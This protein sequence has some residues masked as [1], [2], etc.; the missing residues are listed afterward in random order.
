MKPHVRI[1]RP[2]ILSLS[3]CLG[4]GIG[5]A[6]RTAVGLEITGTFID[7]FEGYAPATNP[8]D[9]FDTGPDNS[10]TKVG[11][12]FVTFE[13]G[14]ERF[15]GTD[16]R[17]RNIHSH[18]I[19]P[20][21]D[22]LENYRLSGR[23][24]ISDDG[25]IGVT[26]LSQYPD[27]DQYYRLRRFAGTDFHLSPHGTSISGGDTQ[28]GVT[29]TADTW[30]RFL[31]EVDAIGDRTEIRAKVW[32]DGEPEPTAWQIDAYDDSPARLV[33]GRFGLWS[34]ARGSKYFDDIAVELLY[35][36]L[37]IGALPWSRKPGF[38]PPVN[39][40]APG[41]SSAGTS[42]R[43]TYR[44]PLIDDDS[45]I[46]DYE[47]PCSALPCIDVVPNSGG[48]VSTTRQGEP[49]L[50]VDP[51]PSGDFP[52]WESSRTPSLNSSEWTLFVDVEILGDGEPGAGLIAKRRDTSGRY[53]SL[54]R[55]GAG[56]DVVFAWNDAVA[57]R[58]LSFAGG[59]PGLGRHRLVL[60][61]DHGTYVYY[62]NSVERGRTYDP[63]RIPAS[64]DG[65]D[66]TLGV[67]EYGPP[68]AGRLDACYFNVW[69]NV[70]HAI[71]AD[72]AVDLFI[73]PWQI[74]ENTQL[75]DA[76]IGQ[77]YA[78]EG[79]SL[80]A[81]GGTAPYTWT[82]VSGALPPGLQLSADGHLSGTATGGDTGLPYEISVEV[83][84]ATGA[85]ATLEFALS[86]VEL[87]VAVPSLALRS[88]AVASLL[89]LGLGALALRART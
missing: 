4:I 83:R 18:F 81:F 68:A 7:D 43:P 69:I 48:G 16:S 65:H 49:C 36:P 47:R 58:S 70:Y 35:P 75:R 53:W 30:Y 46:D 12:L 28:S 72:D 3:L 11:G 67:L 23:M 50:Q 86:L 39:R 59:W 85:A 76:V 78:G 42:P 73:N 37:A 22:E 19:G 71:S 60:T 51:S 62:I 82:I 52:R 10:L 27:A 25:G 61:R 26:F 55:D 31:V 24:R 32:E 14:G 64:V 6:E 77:P 44:I 40:Y 54:S 63:N 57:H 56:P 17:D 2:S 8:D 45:L 79:Q 38:E 74:Y 13:A 21:S 34:T 84:D 66:L 87:G 80:A 1:R 5:V 20:G 33:R 41:M 9:W 29:P 15:F 88:L 89:L